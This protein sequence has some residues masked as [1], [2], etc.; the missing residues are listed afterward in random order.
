MKKIILILTTFLVATGMYAQKYD[1]IRNTALLQQFQ[2]AKDDLDKYY[3][4]LPIYLHVNGYFF[5]SGKMFRPY[6]SFSI[7]Y[8]IKLK[9][10]VDSG[11]FGL[12]MVGCEF[13]FGKF[14]SVYGE[15][16]GCFKYRLLFQ[17]GVGV[18]F[19]LK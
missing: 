18:K 16:G 12:G 11:L 6:I 5:K 17:A 10:Y 8:L 9:D 13:N 7:A 1:A 19:Y 15:V 14:F 3:Y 2:K 4:G